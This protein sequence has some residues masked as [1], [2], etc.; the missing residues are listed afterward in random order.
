MITSRYSFLLA[1]PGAQRT[2]ENRLPYRRDRTEERAA[3]LSV[4]RHARRVE[5]AQEDARRRAV[6][7]GLEAQCTRLELEDTSRVERRAQLHQPLSER[8][9]ERR[10][11][12]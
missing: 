4:A 5:G 9:R 2:R 7:A 6:G 11:V 8:R 1:A 12:T 3:E 10:W